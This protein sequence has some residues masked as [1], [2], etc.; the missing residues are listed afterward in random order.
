MD[1]SS[2]LR[3]ACLESVGWVGVSGSLIGLGVP[4]A[5]RPSVTRKAL[6]YNTLRDAL[7]TPP[8]LQ[9]AASCRWQRAH[10]TFRR[11]RGQRNSPKCSMASRRKIRKVG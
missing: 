5:G 1:C 11:R 10:S 7:F 8:N 9:N 6:P 2:V 4:L 3:I